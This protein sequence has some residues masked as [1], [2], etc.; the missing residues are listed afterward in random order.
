MLR[1]ITL[2]I[3]GIAAIWSVIK[4]LLDWIGYVDAFLAHRQDLG[5]IAGLMSFLRNPPGWLPFLVMTVGG[6]GF[7]L[8]YAIR[9]NRASLAIKSALNPKSVKYSPL[10]LRLHSIL[11][12]EKGI[13][14][15]ARR[16]EIGSAEFR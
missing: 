10:Y 5:W 9:M 1:I 2:A 15:A 16:I 12:P 8:D 4:F 11:D 3:V 7:L 6:I 13:H 14:T